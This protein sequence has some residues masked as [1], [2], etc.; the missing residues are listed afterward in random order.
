[1][2]NHDYLIIFS[3]KFCFHKWKKYQFKA[4]FLC[5]QRT[6]TAFFLIIIILQQLNHILTSHI[7]QEKAHNCYIASCHCENAQ[8]TVLSEL[9]FWGLWWQLLRLIAWYCSRICM[10]RLR[11]NKMW[12]AI[13]WIIKVFVVHLKLL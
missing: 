13:H 9:W 8:V 10:D 3:N 6:E 7:M 5:T 2:C 1:M 11:G 4:K 12:W